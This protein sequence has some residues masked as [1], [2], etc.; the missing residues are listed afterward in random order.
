MHCLWNPTAFQAI[1]EY[2]SWE[3]ELLEDDSIRRHITTG[4]FVPI[5]IHA[6]GCFAIEVRV[7]TSAEP[8][9]LSE[10]ESK[11]LTVA[12]EPYR[13]VSDGTLC[14]SGIE[15]VHQ[16]P[17]DSVGVLAL[18]KGEFEV[19]VFLIGWDAEPGMQDPRG[20]PKKN[21]LPD[22]VV[23]LNPKRGDKKKYRTEVETFPPPESRRR[24]ADI[25]PDHLSGCEQRSTLAR[26]VV[27]S[28]GMPWKSSSVRHS[29]R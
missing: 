19:T 10:R 14:I 4:H 5:N 1:E 21:A 24:T 2:K 22:F 11:Y 6:D 8:E 20:R 15:A 9:S 27:T 7:G 25:R 13:F 12:S 16:E 17:D 28:D 26:S 29:A 3:N 23:L 18:A